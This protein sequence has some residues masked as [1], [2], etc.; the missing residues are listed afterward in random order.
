MPLVTDIMSFGRQ[1]DPYQGSYYQNL[2]AFWKG[3]VQFHNLTNLTTDS[4]IQPPFWINDAQT[5][6]T[7]ANLTNATELAER[8]GNWRW[9]HSTKTSI[10]FA[11]K[12][13]SREDGEKKDLPEDIAL[14]HVCM[15]FL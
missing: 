11:D 13:A 12:K 6:V 10:R 9:S 8:V 15:I 3:D 7:S 4:Q 5:F 2:T 1:L 14:I